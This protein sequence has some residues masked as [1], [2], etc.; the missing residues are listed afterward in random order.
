MLKEQ[1]FLNIFYSFHLKYPSKSPRNILIFLFTVT[2]CIFFLLIALEDSEIYLVFS[3]GVLVSPILSFI[4]ILIGVLAT[5]IPVYIYRQFLVSKA[6]YKVKKSNV[7]WIGITGSYG[8]TSVKEFIYQLLA[9]QFNTAKTDANRNTDVGIA[10]SILKNL[11]NDTEFFVAEFG[12]YR[13]GEIKKASSYIP[14]SYVVLTGLGNQHVDL[15]G[16]RENLIAEETYLLYTLNKF[17]HAY[18]KDNLPKDSINNKDI[19]SEKILYGL[20]HT[21]NIR[22]VLLPPAHS[23]QKAK[24]IYKHHSFIV[25]TRL[26]GTHTIENLLPAIAISLDLGISTETIIKKIRKLEPIQGKLSLHKGKN[27][28]VIINDAANSNTEGFIAAIHTLNSLP[29]KSKIIVSQGIIE[30]G[31]EKRDSYKRILEELLKTDIVLFTTDKVFKEI[32]EKKSEGRVKTFNDVDTMQKAL[33]FSI[34]HHTAILVEGKFSDSF[35]D[36]LL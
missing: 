6:K 15:Y 1:G 35:M 11:K 32:T 27:K 26:L 28:A 14:L 2:C 16:S 10:I 24:I 20:N 7:V 13:K 18:I 8:K 19:A 17:G 33:L 34:N 9:T 29:Y 23:F 3:Y 22:A 31:V 21:A 5:Q 30:L 12:A 36:S 4:L 25:E